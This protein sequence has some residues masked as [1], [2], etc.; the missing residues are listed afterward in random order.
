MKNLKDSRKVIQT[1]FEMKNVHNFSLV[2]TM[3]EK[4][5]PETIVGQLTPSGNS[6]CIDTDKSRALLKN[7]NFEILNNEICSIFPIDYLVFYVL[8]QNFDFLR[9]TD[10]FWANILYVQEFFWVESL[11]KTCLYVHE[12]LQRNPSV[13]SCLKFF[14][15]LP[16]GFDYLGFLTNARRGAMRSKPQWVFYWD[17]D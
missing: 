2:Q 9:K 17:L 16:Y 5:K 13:G 1:K 8:D 11:Q 14:I 15:F 12:K 10:R 3:E 6:Y 7:Q 4:T